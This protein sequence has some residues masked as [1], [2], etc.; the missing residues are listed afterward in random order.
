[1]KRVMCQYEMKANSKESVVLQVNIHNTL[2]HHGNSMEFGLITLAVSYNPIYSAFHRKIK[3]PAEHR[4]SA[5]PS[6]K[7]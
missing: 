1:M 6:D 2:H 7:Q 4:L 3:N 5:V